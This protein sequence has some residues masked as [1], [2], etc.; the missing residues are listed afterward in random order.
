MQKGGNLVNEEKIIVGVTNSHIV[1]AS[2]QSSLEKDD[3]GNQELIH[4]N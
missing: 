1:A 3:L 4:R 2:K